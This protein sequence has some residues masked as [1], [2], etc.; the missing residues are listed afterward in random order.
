MPCG[1]ILILTSPF[2]LK[3]MHPAE[4]PWLNDLYVVSSMFG[5]PQPGYLQHNH[6]KIVS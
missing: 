4:Y 5:A 1:C 6:S 3:I 2:R